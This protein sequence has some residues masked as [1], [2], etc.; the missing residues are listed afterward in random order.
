MEEEMK[1]ITW[2]ANF[3]ICINGESANWSDLSETA[4]A[5]ILDCIKNGSYSGMFLD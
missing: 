3:E 1:D 5:V 4:K 2:S